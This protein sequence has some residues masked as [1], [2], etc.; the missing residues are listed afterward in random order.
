MKKYTIALFGHRNIPNKQEVRQALYNYLKERIRGDVVRVLIGTH[1]DFDRIALGICKQLK[2]EG[3][4]INIS[5][6]YTSQKRLTRDVK[7]DEF[8]GEYKGIELLMYDIEEIHYKRQIIVSNQNMVDDSNEVIVYY[9]GKS[10]RQLHNGTERV[11]ECIKNQNKPIVN[12]Y[13]IIK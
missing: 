9:T 11:V 5:L 8:V 7:A 6:V 2:R 3:F 13:N 10:Q 12:L 1:G 4:D